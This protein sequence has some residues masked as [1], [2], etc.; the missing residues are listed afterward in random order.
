[1]DFCV[2]VSFAPVFLFILV[3]QTV[4]LKMCTHLKATLTFSENVQ[5]HFSFFAFFSSTVK[6]DIC[7]FHISGALGGFISFMSGN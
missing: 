3:V 7:L 1:M 5:I 4:V 2:N 6:I